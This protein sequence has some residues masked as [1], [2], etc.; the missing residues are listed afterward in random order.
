MSAGGCWY[1]DLTQTAVYLYL[2]H[3]TVTHS[4]QLLCTPQKATAEISCNECPGALASEP[5]I[6]HL[7][8]LRCGETGSLHLQVARSSPGTLTRKSALQLVQ[9]LAALCANTS[10]PLIHPPL[11]SHQ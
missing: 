6:A 3:A 1:L 10:V 7:P 11:P 5:P 4:H 8:Q 9:G 2:T